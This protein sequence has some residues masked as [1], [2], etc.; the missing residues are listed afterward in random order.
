LWRRR[1][2]GAHHRLTGASHFLCRPIPTV[3]SD[4][5]CRSTSLSDPATLAALCRARRLFSNSLSDRAVAVNV[6]TPA[7]ARPCG[8]DPGSEEGTSDRAP[9]GPVRATARA[10]TQPRTPPPSVRTATMNH[11]NNRTNQ[12]NQ[13]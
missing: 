1:P 11:H 5:G 8:T 12:P 9:P 13:R 7:S 10:G 2:P 3:P 4:G 6:R